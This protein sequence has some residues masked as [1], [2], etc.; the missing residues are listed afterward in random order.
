[1][2]RL[3]PSVRDPRAG[4]EQSLRVL[5]A[6]KRSAPR[7]GLALHT[8]SSLMLGLGERED[9][10]LESMRALRGVD[11]DFL[12]LGQYLQ[13]DRWN[14]PVVEFI[15]PERFKA[16]ERE[17]LALG[18]RYV[19]SGPLVRSS[20]R[21]A[22]F[23]IARQL[24]AAESSAR[25]ADRTTERSPRVADSATERPPRGADHRPDPTPA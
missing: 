7:H 15:R 11:V 5:D 1:V 25:G 4:F 21:A 10:V 14:L 22:E 3:T 16:L 18:F 23:F 12:T 20:Y 17:G 24:R 13:P 8:K 9:E 6:A 2:P 19:A